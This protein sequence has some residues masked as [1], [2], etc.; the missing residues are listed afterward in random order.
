[1]RKT[2]AFYFSFLCSFLFQASRMARLSSNLENGRVYFLV[3]ILLPCM[4]PWD[5]EQSVAFILPLQSGVL[6][7]MDLLHQPLLQPPTSSV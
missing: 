3:V 6:P 5:S 1:M 7:A 2:P 4:F